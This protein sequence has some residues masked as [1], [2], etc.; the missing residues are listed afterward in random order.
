MEMKSY[1]DLLDLQKVDLQIDRLLHD[2]ENLPELALY[3]TAHGKVEELTVAE[4]DAVEQLRQTA[5]SL[6]RTQGE[7]G[8]AET[9]LEREQLRLYSGGMSARD[10][11]YLRREVEMLRSNKAKM[12]DELLRL[13][14][15]SEDLEQVAEAAKVEL[16]KLTIEKDRLAA[17]IKDEWRVLDAELTRREV[18]KVE[19]LPS[20]DADMVALYE[21]LRALKGGVGVAALDDGVCGGCHLSLTAAEQLEAKRS[22]PPRCIHCRRI[23]VV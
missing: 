4:A 23:L 18:R 9:K 7:L 19:L 13:M 20:I 2:R 11:D 6:D 21:E 17:V 22:D 5:R 12:E 14:E 16:E 8:L 10:A 1:A 3:K 15:S